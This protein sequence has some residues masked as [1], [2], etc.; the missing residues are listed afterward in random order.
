MIT[1]AVL[2]GA[3]CIGVY[4]D[5]DSH[6]SV[7]LIGG[8]DVTAFKA[9]DYCSPKGTGTPIETGDSINSIKDLH[10]SQSGETLRFWYT[11]DVDAI[12]YYT[13]STTT[14]VGG[15]VIPLLPEGQGGRISSMLSLNSADTNNP[16][17]ALVS[18]ILS[19]DENGNLTLLQQDSASQLW[20]TYPF[21]HASSENVIELKG[22]M[23]RMH[24]VASDNGDESSLTPG[25]YL[26]VSSSGVVR[27]IVNGRHATLSPTPKWYQTDAKGV[28]NIMFQNDDDATCHQF[29]ADAFRPA[30]PGSPETVLGDNPLLDP[31]RK[32][33]KKLDGVTTPEDV[34]A[35]RKP[36]G[37]PLVSPDASSEDLKAA[38]DSIS[39]L[40]E[41]AHKYHE[42]SQQHFV[43]FTTTSL[44]SGIR[45]ESTFSLRYSWGDFIDD[46][47]GAWHWVEEKLKDAWKW[48]CEF[49]G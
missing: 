8:K 4:V 22:Y 41:Q 44:E 49:I 11:T 46:V 33:V 1:N 27:C 2:L 19:V 17:P 45:A 40:V 26:R 18:S 23:L 35:L 28:L 9:K 30:K 15:K 5:P 12:H 24:A 47:E 37:T 20:Q 10:V 42:G 25:C 36:D 34:R 43:S 39:V 16:N 38:A 32:L 21:W 48:G 3:T 29:A 7:L 14:L 31:S 6:Q 13:T